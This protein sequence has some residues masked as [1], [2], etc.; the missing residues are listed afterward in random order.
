MAESWQED[1]GGSRERKPLRG[2]QNFP[3]EMIQNKMESYEM[4]K[5][6]DWRDVMG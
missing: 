3:F 5:K 2:R 4:A 6:L 1:V